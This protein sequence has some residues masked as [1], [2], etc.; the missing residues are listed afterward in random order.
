VGYLQFLADLDSLAEFVESDLQFI[1]QS[2]ELEQLRELF[3]FFFDIQS[4]NSSMIK[5]PY[6]IH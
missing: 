4:P 5:V 3:F 1:E 6:F 2:L